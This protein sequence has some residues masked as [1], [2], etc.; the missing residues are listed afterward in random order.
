MFLNYK[1][2]NY[3]KKL[4]AIL[5]LEHMS[6]KLK[7]EFMLTEKKLTAVSEEKEKGGK[8]KSSTEGAIFKYYLGI[9]YV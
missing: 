9:L 2:T 3:I 7:S 5:A 1:F 4:F 8:I 6:K